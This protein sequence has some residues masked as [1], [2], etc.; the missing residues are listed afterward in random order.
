[1]LKRLFLFSALLGVL[2]YTTAQAATVLQLDPL[3]GSIAGLPGSTVGWGFSLN[4]NENFLVVTSAAFE[5]ATELGTFTDLISAPDNFFVVGPAL[6]GSTVWT[7]SFDAATQTGIGSFAIDAGAALGSVAFGTIALT[8]DLFSRSPL[9]PLFDP[10]TDTLSNGNLLTANAS[11]TVP[12]PEP[13]TWAMLLAGIGLLGL[14]L[15]RRPSIA[16]VEEDTVRSL[17]PEGSRRCPQIVTINFLPTQVQ[18]DAANPSLRVVKPC[19]TSI[20]LPQ[21]GICDPNDIRTPDSGRSSTS[22]VGRERPFADAKAEAG[23]NVRF[24]RAPSARAG[25]NQSSRVNRNFR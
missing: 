19:T 21:L 2:S 20:Q 5:A 24:R 22:P 18:R 17:A 12:I 3:G 1:M 13:Q 10:D 7:Q 11:V 14:S 4:N 23:S 16:S 6:G 9:D 8:Y 25:H 15:R